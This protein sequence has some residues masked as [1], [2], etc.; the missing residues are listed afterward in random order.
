MTPEEIALKNSVLVTEDITED[1][2][3]FLYASVRYVN[4]ECNYRFLYNDRLAIEHLIKRLK[5]YLKVKWIDS[6]E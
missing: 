2:N 1:G 6:E 5:E 4:G 3:I